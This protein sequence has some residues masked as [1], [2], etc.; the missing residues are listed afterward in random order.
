MLKIIVGRSGVLGI[1][2][3]LSSFIALAQNHTIALDSQPANSRASTNQAPAL[4][5]TLPEADTLI[6][7]NPQRILNE[8]APKLLPEAELEKMRQQ[9]NG[10]KQFAGVDPSRI[11]YVALIIRFRRPSATLN[12]LP[13]EFLVVTSGDFSAD[14]LVTMARLAMQEKWN[15]EKYGSKALT[16]MT[17]DEIA[18]QSENNPILRSFTQLGLV[19]LS[20]NTIAAGNVD[21]LKS[22]VDAAEGRDRINPETLNSLLR[23]STALVSI[24]GSPWTSFAKSL[25]LMGTDTNPRAPRC[26]SKLGDLYAAVTMEGTA[27]KLRGAMNADNP[28]TAKI[29]NSLISSLLQTAASTAGQDKAA[30]SVLK[31]LNITPRDNEISLEADI[32][33]QM[34]ADFIREQMKPKPAAGAKKPAGKPVRKRTR[35]R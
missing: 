6:Y 21:Y 34:V 14:S 31:M 1:V 10:L 17:F 24:A 32:P 28:D 18:K 22:A 2:L 23:D 8:A 15:E 25:G 4:L 5:S 35:R 12:F 20:A 9:F 19:A 30:Q 7:I 29:I 27:F 16:L 11:E 13:P 26:E 33:Q 3:I